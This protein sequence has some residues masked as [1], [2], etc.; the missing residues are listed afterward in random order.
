MAIMLFFMSFLICNIASNFIKD[1]D[2]FYKSNNV[3]FIYCVVV[4]MIIAAERTAGRLVE[5]IQET[6]VWDI[7]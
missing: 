6:C 4:A 7:T 3:A 5:S 1:T 2:R